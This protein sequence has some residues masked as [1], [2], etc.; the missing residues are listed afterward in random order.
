MRAVISEFGSMLTS[1]LERTG[2]ITRFGL[3]LLA[4]TPGGLLRVRPIIEQVYN[5][6][7]LSLVIIMTCGLFVGMVM[8]LQGYEMLTRFGSEEYLGTA[9]AL[10]L[11]K[12][13][14]P[15][16]TALLFAGRAGTALAAELGLMRATDQIAAMEIMAV[17]PMRRVVL[18]RFLGGVIAMPLLSAIFITIGL[19]GAQLVGVQW[20]G[21][22]Q[23]SFWS[24][25]RGSVE[26]D[27]ISEGLIKGAVFGVACSLIAVY[28]GYHAL[29]TAEGV[30]RA[31]TRTV[32]NSAV[33][34]LVLD[35][36]LTALML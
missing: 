23:G 36:I 31:T 15:V 18:P 19:F 34:T 7:A 35:Y 6:G 26:L 27:D 8:G 20:F 25:M 28:E 21:V 14:G 5:T 3:Q 17:D 29:P 13:L 30:G 33:A 1:F 12:E 4:L 22:D 16:V 24:Q 9:A 32:V 10:S 2:Q 11:L